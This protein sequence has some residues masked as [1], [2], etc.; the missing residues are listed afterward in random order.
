LEQRK[1]WHSVNG[2]ELLR[3]EEQRDASFEHSLEDVTHVLCQL[4]CALGGKEDLGR[5]QVIAL[6]PGAREE[7][8]AVS[9]EDGEDVRPRGELTGELLCQVMFHFLLGLPGR[10]WD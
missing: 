10:G 5:Q 4:G 1:V 2:R 7:R 8:V 3:G 6:R 9:V